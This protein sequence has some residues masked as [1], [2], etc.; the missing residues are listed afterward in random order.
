MNSDSSKSGKIFETQIKKAEELA[1]AMT[2]DRFEHIGAEKAFMRIAEQM[3]QMAK[4]LDDRIDRDSELGSSAQQVRKYVHNVISHIQGICESSAIKQKN[5]ILICEGR[6][7][8]AHMMADAMRKDLDALQKAEIAEAVRVKKRAE[9]MFSKD[10]D[11]QDVPLADAPSDG[12]VVE[13]VDPPKSSGGRRP[14]RKLSEQRVDSNISAPLSSEQRK[15]EAQKT[16]ASA[17]A[18]RRA[19]IAKAKAGVRS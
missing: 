18:A 4:S 19:E 12:P 17:K 1:A 15:I 3:P 16:K 14:V 9:V 6:A 11:K 8:S 7:Q 2:R 5:E 13:V 10:E